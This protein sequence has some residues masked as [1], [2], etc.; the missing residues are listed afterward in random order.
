MKLTIAITTYNRTN[1]IA[2]CLVNIATHPIV[3][4]I[5]ICDDRSQDVE[6][7]KKQVLLISEKVPNPIRLIT[8]PENLGSFWNKVRAVNNCRSGWVCLL[9]SDNI[10]D[11][12][13]L[14]TIQ[15]D[16]EVLMG[17]GDENDVYMPS[18]GWPNLKY[19]LPADYPC[20]KMQNIAHFLA[21]QNWAPTLL[22]TGNFVF[23]TNLFNKATQLA[24]TDP[25]GACS[26]YLNYLFLKAGASLHLHP[27]M[28]YFH[29]IHDDSHWLKTMQASTDFTNGLI[30]NMMQW[31]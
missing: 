22:N 9:D 30:Q 24:D 12:S 29:R 28:R 6:E 11:G 3:E 17:S 26:I 2:Q 1:M 18:V 21:T 14:D 7:L 8:N 16:G 4:E 5:V 13:Y 23:H 27:T 20:L 31:K 19:K 15:A 10:L 25:A